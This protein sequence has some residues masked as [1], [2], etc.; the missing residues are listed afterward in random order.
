MSSK[1]TFYYTI[2]SP[3][4]R[5]CLM[6]IRNLGLAVN[7][8]SLDFQKG[9]HLQEAF[10]K[11]NPL[12]QVPVLVD[13]DFTVTESK[14]ILAYLVNSRKPGSSMYPSDPKLRAVIDQRM[15]YDATVV[16]PTVLGVIRPIIYDGVKTMS[17]EGVDKMIG[18]LNVLDG[19]LSNSKYLAGDNVTIA[20]LSLLGTISTLANL[21]Y[22]LEQHKS[23]G[24]WYE[25]CK[26]IIGFEE[27]D[28][29]AARLAGFIKS[30]V[31]GPLVF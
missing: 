29:G 13:G 9:E 6:L 30:K 24:S 10:L 3:P 7:L 8:E 20:D 23:L 11:I 4:A 15:Y 17:K 16:F 1:L 22:N 19:F 25:S 14:A 28:G 5:G 21:G 2:T 26:S 12:H 18:V 31:D 27:N